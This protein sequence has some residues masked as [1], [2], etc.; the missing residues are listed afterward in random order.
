MGRKK[1]VVEKPKKKVG[2]S[3]MKESMDYK[4][5]VES[6]KVVPALEHLTKMGKTGTVT[7]VDFFTDKLVDKMIDETIE[8]LLEEEV[9]EGEND[10][11]D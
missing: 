3:L 1:K 2:G 7:T 9:G 11:K 5:F 6:I 4:A 10:G 8:E